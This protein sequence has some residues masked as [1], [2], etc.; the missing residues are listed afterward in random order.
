M[1]DPSA[2]HRE[3]PSVEELGELYD[4]P[5]ERL[6]VRGGDDA[7]IAAFLD[8]IE[9]RGPRDREMLRELALAT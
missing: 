3:E 1:H 8:E 5:V 6:R 9:I 2:T 7:A 4:N